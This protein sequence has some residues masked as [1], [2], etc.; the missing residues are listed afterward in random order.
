MK[1]KILTITYIEHEQF[2]VFCVGF[3]M[4]EYGCYF[5]TDIPELL[6]DVKTPIS[7]YKKGFIPMDNLLAILPL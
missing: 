4:S 6:G 3:E 7:Q 1:Y 2:S 5:Y